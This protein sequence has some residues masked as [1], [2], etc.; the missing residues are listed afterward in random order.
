MKAPKHTFSQRQ[1][2]FQELF[3]GTLIYAVVLGLLN[4]YTAVVEVNSFSTIL[5]ASVVLEILTYMT[6]ALKKRIVRWLKNHQGTFFR[7]LTFFSV[8]LVMFLSK[9]VFVWALDLVFGAYI[10]ING[11]FGILLVVVLVTLVQRLAYLTFK[12]LGSS[13]S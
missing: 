13:N 3:I 9:F 10:A 8:W 6:F 5:F 1:L 7:V 2:A 11:F 12:R 4:D